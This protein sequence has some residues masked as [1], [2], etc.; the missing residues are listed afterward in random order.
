MR[1]AACFAVFLALAG[2]CQ[3]SSVSRAI[4]ARC[5][6]SDECDDRCLAP[7]LEWPGGFCT[8]D[9]DS[10]AD[11]I[12]DSS[13]IEDAGGGIC[14]FN[15]AADRNCEFLGEGYTCQE[16]DEHPVSGTKVTVCRG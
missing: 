10:H 8:L 1:V 2:A 6:R 4:G 5:D 13:C 3:D 16:W 7:S 14:A 9:C 12:D 11:C 15:C